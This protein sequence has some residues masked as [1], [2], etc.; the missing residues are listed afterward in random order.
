[1][2][3]VAR[4]SGADYLLVEDAPMQDTDDD[5]NGAGNVRTLLNLT[6]QHAWLFDFLWYIRA[7]LNPKPCACTESCSAG[8][9]CLARSCVAF[10][11]LSLALRVTHRCSLASAAH[12]SEKVGP[13]HSTPSRLT[14][15]RC[16]AR[17][18]DMWCGTASRKLA[19]RW[20][21]WPMALAYPQRTEI[22]A[23]D[24]TFADCQR[25]LPF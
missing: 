25:A 10:C 14:A 9:P 1:M 15:V 17:R 2:L 18:R 3:Q 19:G 21:W 20:M 5:D 13:T 7:S 24:I 23:L 22:Y 6:G 11:V 4:G 8:N 12:A 16:T